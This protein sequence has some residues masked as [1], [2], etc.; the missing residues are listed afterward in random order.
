MATI[1]DI[2]ERAGVSLTTVSRLLNYD[3]TLNVQDETKKKVFEAA[4]QLE[5]HMKEKKK[6]KRRLKLGVIC[7]YSLEEELEDVFYL[8]VRIAIEKEIE[9]A[10]YKRVELSSEVNEEQAAQVDGLICLGTF[11]RTAAHNIEVLNRPTIFVDAIANRDVSDSIVTDI[12]HSVDKVME[13]FWEQGH[14]KIGFIGGREIDDDGKEVMDSRLPGYENFLRQRGLFREAYVKIGGYTPRYGYQLAGELLGEKEP[15]TAIFAAN[16]SL[17][18]GCYRA[19]IEKGL[20]IP[21]D[22][23][24]IGFNDIPMAKYLTPPLTTIH[25]H[26]NFL[27]RQAVKMI[28]EKILTDRTISMHVSV[29]TNLV[30][31]ESVAGID[32]Q[33]RQI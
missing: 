31:R 18:V 9:E 3:E 20:R 4:E 8:S 30:L 13:Y 32:R 14:R 25:V 10:G 19:I 16:D 1:K 23:S 22:V 21:E 28:S 2:A 12:R 29:P 27:G 15:P 7:S 5:Y 24:V 17:A 26:M 33:E 11:S 6:R